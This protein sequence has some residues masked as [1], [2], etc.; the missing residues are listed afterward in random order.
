M[1]E[2]SSTDHTWIFSGIGVF[3]LSLIVGIISHFL[4]NNNAHS[5]NT[6]VN[7]N[8]ANTAFIPTAG[9]PDKESDKD[10]EISDQILK[11]KTHILFID[12]DQKF[13]VVD[14]LKRH[15]WS[16]IQRV[17]DISSLDEDRVINA[18]LFFV[19]I[20]GVGKRLHFREEGLGLA[21]AIKEKYPEKKIVIYSAHTQGE[22]FHDALRQADDFL[23]KD[24]DPYEFQQLAHHLASDYWKAMM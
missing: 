15:G 4:K 23:S 8:N 19:D 7:I 11:A 5:N 18:H 24:A 22:R 16:H 21:A 12:D 13:K 14:I 20:Q 1:F 6:T 17:S 10:R 9:I 3:V 2:L